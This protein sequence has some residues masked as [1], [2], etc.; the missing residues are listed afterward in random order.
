MAGPYRRGANAVAV[1]AFTAAAALA[2]HHAIS[3]REYGWTD[4]RLVC[5]VAFAWLVFTSIFPYLHRDIPLP[6]EG[7]HAAA[8]LDRMF[9]TVI[10]PAHNEDHA[11]FRAFLDSLTAQTRT[12]NRLHIVENGNPGYIPTLEPVLR[13]WQRAGGAQGVDVRYS[14]N[15][16]GDKRHAQAVAF[17]QDRD[18]DIIVTIDSDVKLAPT[19]IAAGLAAFRNSR[20]ACVTGMLVGLNTTA[21]LLTRLVEPAFVCAY[22][23][24]R[25]AH[26]L[27]RSVAVNSGAL[28]FYRAA[29]WDKYLD[30][31]LTHT[32]AGRKMKSGDDAMMT[33]Y[34]LLEGEA[35]FQA[36]CWGYTL[37][38]EKLAQLTSQRIRW[39]RSLFWGG[40]WTLRVFRPTRFV[41]WSTMWSFLSMTW[42]AVV[43]PFVLIIRPA[44]LGDI[45]WEIAAWAFGLTYI[46][47]A[48]YL[49]IARPGEPF[50][51]H[52]SLWAL[53]PLASL[54]NFY[55][56]FCLAYIGLA[57]CLKDGWG[58]RS[59][60]L[61]YNPGTATDLPA[62]PRPLYDGDPETQLLDVQDLRNRI[63]QTAR[64]VGVA[65]LAPAPLPPRTMDDETETR[66]LWATPRQPAAAQ[67]QPAPP[68]AWPLAR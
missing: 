23:N 52:L 42:M 6:L 50:R 51:A 16:V 24:G 30:H 64:A 63:T 34:A 11:M 31:Y 3:I 53:A 32:V 36:G 14:F 33:R 49:T 26:S 13:Q 48:R 2:T 45:P 40:V 57:T 10:V 20:T 21:N 59:T 47:G 28:S 4:L 62:P 60:V 12:V 44:A 61:A 58:S 17:R 8:M 27:L 68:P 38:P 56:G 22:L 39:W 19:A 9:V 18:A 65:R 43:M 35:L 67:A 7:T 46:T 41:W 66:R 54:L 37:H 25:A 1:V 55:T 5:T 29:I 15:P